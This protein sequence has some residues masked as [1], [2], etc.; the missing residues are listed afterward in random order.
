MRDDYIAVI[1]SGIG[2]LNVLFK[3]LEKYPNERFLYFSD[4]L[5][6]PY[7]NKNIGELYSI[8]CKNI[9]YVKKYG[10]K[11]LVLGCNTL[12]SNLLKEISQ[13]SSVPTFGITPP[14][15]YAIKHYNRILLLATVRT[16]Q[17]YK[18]VN[19]VDVVG[20]RDLAE[21][22]ERNCFNL[23]SIDF[24]DHLM[25]RSEGM[26]INQKGWY[27]VVVLGCTHYNF[28]KNQIFD[29][30]KPQAIICSEDFL[31]L[32][33]Y[34]RNKNKKSL[35]KIRRFEVLFVGDDAERNKKIACQRWF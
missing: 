18:V 19:R 32:I 12:S 9:D 11:A 35:E 3:L 13:Y 22:I 10:I 29:H 8:A 7:G 25:N 28:I 17:K 24:T 6:A 16:A 27:D 20:M 14:I 23:Q 2:G 4:S 15:N 26:H 1:D 31:P 21:D 33:T 5:N 34:E 30:L